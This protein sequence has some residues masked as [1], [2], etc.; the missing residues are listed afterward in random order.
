MKKILI[1]CF[2]ILFF[3]MLSKAQTFEET[4]VTAKE[5]EQNILMVFSGSDW[6]KPC[7]QMKE[8]ILKTT[9]F[10]SFSKDNLILLIVDFPYRKKNQLAKEQQLHNE[11]LAEKYNQE[12]SF[13]KAILLT[14][15][16]EILGNITYE[17]NMQPNI[18]IN[19][20]EAIQSKTELNE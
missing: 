15:N 5:R 7:I 11:K 12:G 17:Q 13:P 8:T 16:E 20:I 9:A 2:I 10:E 19:Q 6:C 1:S 14:A 4:L 18:F 3:S